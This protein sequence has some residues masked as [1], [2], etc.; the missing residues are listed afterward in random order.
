MSPHLREEDIC[1]WMAG[2]RSLEAERHLAH[3][4]ECS[5]HVARMSAVLGEFR[6]SVHGRSERALAG[7]GN[8]RAGRPRGLGWGRMAVAGLAALLIALAVWLPQ[9]E[10]RS[11]QDVDDAALLRR[12][13]AEVSRTVP[14]PMEPLA[15][16]MPQG[17]RTQEER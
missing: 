15:A 2:E 13:D 4:G 3:C 1:R 9:H 8:L 10:S 17:V 6:D 7:L 11:V 14:G 16:L 5:S 12:V